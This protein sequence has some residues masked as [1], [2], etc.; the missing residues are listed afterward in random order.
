MNKLINKIL[1]TS[2]KNIYRV[3]LFIFICSMLPV[4]YLG[5]FAVPS[6][7][8]YYFGIMPHQ[9]W[10]AEH[11]LGSVIRGSLDMVKFYYEEKQATYTSIFIMAMSPSVINE[12]FYFVTPL[13]LTGMFI[14]SISVLVHVVISDCLGAKNKYLTGIANLLL[15]FMAIQTILVPL[16]ALFWYNGGIHYVFMQSV[17]Y[18]EI[19]TVLHFLNSTKKSTRIVM[20]ILGSFLGFLVGGGNLISGLQACILGALL[21]MYFILQMI[22]AKKDNAFIKMIGV[23]QYIKENWLAAIPI[24]VTI[25][26]YGANALA[27]CNSLRA[28]VETQMNPIKAVINSFYWGAVYTFSWINTMSV[29]VLVIITVIVWKLAKD[30]TKTFINPWVMAILSYCIFSAMLTPTWY[31]MSQDAPNRVKNIIGTARYIIIFINIVND[32]GYA[33]SKKEEAGV[34]SRVLGQTESSYKS[35]VIIGAVLV[36]LVFLLAADKNTYTSMS[37][38]RSVLTGEAS[39]YY[40]QSFERIDLY[41]DESMPDVVVKPL[42]DDAKPYLLFKE[43]ISDKEGE[44]GYWQSVEISDYYGKNSITVSAE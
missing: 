28:Q 34:I 16:E 19:A 40:S 15:V 41:N 2:E 23:G 44:E 39:R 26:A 8:D 36:G 29:L 3:I 4:W 5:R 11:T 13:I 32:C 17:L 6:L 42:T 7:D 10:L 25:V 9:A 20:L 38:L 21:I 33:R 35:I 27:P 31:A 24:V 12:R 43:D 18:F 14:G 1:N 30:T 37:A 22:A